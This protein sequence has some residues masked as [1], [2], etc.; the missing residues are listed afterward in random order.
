ME[1]GVGLIRRAISVLVL[2]L[3]LGFA[4]VASASTA[5]AIVPRTGHYVGHDH[6]LHHISLNYSRTF[7]VN[8]FKIGDHNAGAYQLTGI[9]WHGPCHHGFCTSGKWV[10]SVKIQGHWWHEGN[11][12]HKIGYVAA[13]SNPVGGPG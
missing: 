9:E 10:S 11:P 6:N 2:A 7:H 4:S 12:G 5:E 8:H 3:G 1:K 13:W